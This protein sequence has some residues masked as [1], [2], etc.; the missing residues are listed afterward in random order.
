MS[1]GGSQ[2]RVTSLSPASGGEVARRSRRA[3]A[4]HGS[5]GCAGQSLLVAAVVGEAHSNLDGLTLVGLSQGV[6][7]AGGPVY[8]RIVGQPLVAGVGVLQP[9]VV[10]DPRS[11]RRQ[12]LS[13]LGPSPYGWQAGRRN[14]ELCFHRTGR[15]AGQSLLV[16]AVVGEAHSDLDSL[17]NIV[18][19][20]RIGCTGN[21]LY[22]HFGRAVVGY[23]L[24]AE[25]CA[26]Q[27]VGVLDAGR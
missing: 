4:P 23:P 2:D 15:C 19:H 8:G 22:I 7:P 26:A 17:P 27:T 10:G 13:H 11:V 24:I 1:A 3:V 20:E 21:F 14:I 6:F 16:A 12:R 5:R 9:V 18:S 25:G